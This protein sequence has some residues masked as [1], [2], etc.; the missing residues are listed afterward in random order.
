MTEPSAQSRTSRSPRK[1]GSRRVIRAILTTSLLAISLVVVPVPR[2]VWAT[3]MATD[4]VQPTPAPVGDSYVDPATVPDFDAVSA[5]ADV[6]RAD[7]ADPSVRAT[8]VDHDAGAFTT[9][10]IGWDGAVSPE[11]VIVRTRTDGAWDEWHRFAFSEDHRPDDDAPAAI[12][13]PLW[14]GAADAYEIQYPSALGSPTVHLV[15]ETEARVA[16]DFDEP[17]AG[18]DPTIHSRSEWGARQPKVTPLSANSL[19]VAIVHHSVT[20]NDYSSAQVPSILRSIQAFHMDVRG[21]DDIAYNFAVDRFGRTWEARAGG[22]DRPVIGGHAY[23]FNVGTTGVLV[24]GTYDAVGPSAAS[25]AAVSDLI[26]WKFAQHHVPSTGTVT[27]Y[28]GVAT[29][30]GPAGTPVTLNRISGHRN[31][32]QTGCPGA[33]LYDRLDSIRSSV[34]SRIVGH[35]QSA[36]P[37]LIG[38][39][40]TGGGRDDALVYHPGPRADLDFAGAAGPDLVPASTGVTGLYEPLAGDFDGNGIS[41]IFWYRPGGASDYL[42]YGLSGRNHRDV[43]TNIYG[44]YVPRVGDFDG[45]GAD[46]I[47]WYGDYGTSDHLY[48][49]GPGGFVPQRLTIDDHVTPIVGDF[50]GDGADDLFWYGYGSR[51]DAMTWGRSDRAIVLDVV[52]VGGGYEPFVGD[53]DGNGA[54]D[55]FWYAPGPSSDFVWSGDRSRAFTSHGDPAPGVHDPIA[56]DFDGDGTDDVMWYQ[57]GADPD[58]L[59]FNKPSGRVLE[60]RPVG[61]TYQTLV[62]DADGSGADELLWVADSNIS[63]LW[64]R[65]SAGGHKSIRVN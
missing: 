14:V 35:L 36:P 34:Q 63:Y 3:E 57:A 24:L 51:P 28:P 58:V 64:S 22:I 13:E 21:W 61:G 48:W 10:G 2:L 62:L 1:R 53:F 12:G 31:T 16:L 37:I 44:D 60:S 5:D 59:W 52:S 33:R 18:A 9:I 20:S 6:S 38:G 43:K 29:H 49:G 47:L 32:G 55:I 45:D 19:E 25:T 56:G 46:D 42:W 54:D 7:A 39:D 41:D 40:R 26:A 65:T 17:T 8:V 23:G 15:R 11:A 30:H 4:S 27:M 50:D